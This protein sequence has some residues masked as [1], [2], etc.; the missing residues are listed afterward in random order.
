MDPAGP[1]HQPK[2]L[3]RFVLDRNSAGTSFAGDPNVSFDVI[4]NSGPWPDDPDDNFS[5]RSHGL[6]VIARHLIEGLERS[7]G[8][9]YA[10]AQLR[11]L[12]RDFPEEKV[13][14]WHAVMFSSAEEESEVR[15]AIE[16]SDRSL[17]TYLNDD[18]TLVYMR[19]SED[20]RVTGTRDR[21]RP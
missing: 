4:M 19:L 10:A 14:S 17:A 9:S 16:T 6:V 2:R 7:V 20:G 5:R 18:G 3:A 15:A 13:D 8:D 11:A 21:P 12:D 1:L